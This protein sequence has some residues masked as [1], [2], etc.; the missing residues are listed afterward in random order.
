MQSNSVA[1]LLFNLEGF[2]NHP[3]ERIRKNHDYYLLK[4]NERY[5]GNYPFSISKSLRLEDG[6]KKF[7]FIHG[8]E[9]EV[10]ANLEPMSIE[11]YENF[12]E[13]MCFVENVIGGLASR[14][15][16][17]VEKGLIRSHGH[18]QFRDRG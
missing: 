7:Y 5:A 13:K 15:W 18:F 2:G 6:G 17:L 4:L 1:Y 16:S 14:L 11:D 12:S 9:L 10:L 8:Y 3:F